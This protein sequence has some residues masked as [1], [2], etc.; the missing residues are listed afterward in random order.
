MCKYTIFHLECGHKGEDRADTRDCSHY[1]AT[2]VPCDRENPTIRNRVSVVSQDRKGLCNNCT[3]RQRER[4]ELAAMQRDLDRIREQN[5]AEAKERQRAH[6]EHERKMERQSRAEWDRMQRE[7]E[8]RDLDAALKASEAAKAEEKRRQQKELD[9]LEKAM[10]ESRLQ[11]PGGQ[12]DLDGRILEWTKSVKETATSPVGHGDSSSIPAPPPMPPT[13]GKNSST[14]ATK[15]ASPPATP[16]KTTMPP[17]PPTSERKLK[18][19]NYSLPPVGKQDYGRFKM[20]GRSVPIHESQKLQEPNPEVPI[21][22][23]PSPYGR[24]GGPIKAADIPSFSHMQGGSVQPPTDYKAGLR[25]F[26][27]PKPPAPTA[28]DAS[29]DELQAKLTKRRQWEADEEATSPTPSESASNIGSGPSTPTTSEL[30]RTSTKRGSFSGP[31]K[32]RI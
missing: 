12:S 24:L 7:R 25:K 15:P 22:N 18:E 29:N 8:Q 14:S 23:A 28:L 20:G 32:R 11:S 30:G 2:G 10:R 31:G 13:P 6:E 16:A 26:S 27:N 21:P 3:R 5:L 4:D 19:V 1:K 9:D 17:S